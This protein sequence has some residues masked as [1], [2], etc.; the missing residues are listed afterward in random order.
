MVQI[1]S[2][3]W[4]LLHAVGMAKKRRE[5]EKRRKKRKERKRKGTAHLLGSE[6]R[7]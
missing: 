2:L 5:K 7:K 4:E 1:Q 3:A 6:Q